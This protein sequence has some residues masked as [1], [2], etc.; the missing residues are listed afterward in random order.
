MSTT[1]QQTEQGVPTGTWKADTVHSSIAFEVPYTVAKFSGEVP[2]FEASLEDGTLKGVAKVASLQL[3]DENLTAHV[4]GPDFFDAEQHPELSFEGTDFTRTGDRVE[5]AGQ[6]TLKGVTKPA[7]LKGT[8]TGPSP[9]AYAN[10]RVGL[11]LETTVDRT[12]FG[13]DWNADLPNGEK[14]LGNEVTLRA[15]LSLVGA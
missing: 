2:E 11:Q 14:A 1:E 9:D 15:D 13:I 4:Q 8:I 12:D 5:L 3:K 10:Q 6:I 7:T